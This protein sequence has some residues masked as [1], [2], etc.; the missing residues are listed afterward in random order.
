MWLRY[1]AFSHLLQ[2]LCERFRAVECEFV[3]CPNLHEPPFNTSSATAAFLGSDISFVS[4]STS[5]ADFGKEIVCQLKEG[6]VI[7]KEASAPREVI[8]IHLENGDDWKLP[9]RNVLNASSGFSW[10]IFCVEARQNSASALFHLLCSET[11]ACDSAVIDSTILIAPMKP[12]PAEQPTSAMS[13]VKKMASMFAGNGKIAEESSI[14]KPTKIVKKVAP[15]TVSPTT[16]SSE[17]KTDAKTGKKSLISTRT[18]K[19]ANGA[20][21]IKKNIVDRSTPKENTPDLVQEVREEITNVSYVVKLGS[22][23]APDGVPNNEPLP[24]SPVTGKPNQNGEEKGGTPPEAEEANGGTSPEAKDV[25]KLENKEVPS[26]IKEPTVANGNGEAAAETADDQNGVV[27]KEESPEEAPI[28]VHEQNGEPTN[29]QKENGRKSLQP[30]NGTNGTHFN[31]TFSREDNSSSSTIVDATKSHSQTEIPPMDDESTQITSSSI[32]ARL[33]SIRSQRESSNESGDGGKT[34]SRSSEIGNGVRSQLLNDVE[35]DLSINEDSHS[36]GFSEVLK[37]HTMPSALDNF[38]L[39]RSPNQMPIIVLQKVLKFMSFDEL[40]RIRQVTPIW[41]EMCGQMLNAG[42]Y[43]LTAQA[44]RLLTECQRR[45]HREAHLS[46]PIQVLTKLQL[47]VI[48]PVDIMRVAMDEGVCC[49]PYGKILDQAFEVLEKVKET[50][51]LK[52][53]LIPIQWEP[54]AELSRRAQVHYKVCVEGIIEERMG[55]VMN[56]KAQQRLQRID[57][58]MIEN[59]VSKLERVATQ[60]KDDLHWEIEQLKSQNAQ[61]RKD[62]RDIKRDY[63]KLE[64]R[65]EVLERKFKTVARLLQ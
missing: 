55:E 33:V 4:P 1:I 44:D 62:N 21:I 61:L 32:A 65:V 2:S 16:S 12:E 37:L 41:D 18:V 40:A 26:D 20:K 48:N 25:I 43:D 42:Y 36:S 14:K 59:T 57:S 23:P 38:F 24:H 47:H 53:D 31:Q 17:E 22:S 27:E 8:R 19:T 54:V 29:G 13:S 50:I 45:V 9:I 60:A 5:S 56:L 64:S 6:T 51:R 58:F 10:Q 3:A 30:S 39:P 49:F 52:E 63:M 28:A 11:T 7:T 35:S 34:A 15:K 46:K